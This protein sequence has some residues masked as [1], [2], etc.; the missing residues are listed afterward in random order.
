[1]YGGFSRSRLR[2]I[3]GKFCRSFG[4][5]VVLEDGVVLLWGSEADLCLGRRVTG[6]EGRGRDFFYLVC[7]VWGVVGGYKG[8]VVGVGVILMLGF[9]LWI[10][11]F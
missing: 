5:R 3:L 1:M 7:G 9:V 6:E 2:F 10:V 11:V 8:E 4:F